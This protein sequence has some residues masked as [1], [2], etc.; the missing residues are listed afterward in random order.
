MTLLLYKKN[1]FDFSLKVGQKGFFRCVL[2][3]KLLSSR[4]IIYNFHAMTYIILSIFYSG[5]DKNNFIILYIS[6]WF[7]LLSISHDLLIIYN[8]LINFVGFLNGY[9]HQNPEKQTG[10]PLICGSLN[11]DLMGRKDKRVNTSKYTVGVATKN[12]PYPTYTLVL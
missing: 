12:N 9:F 7:S 4:H 11:W 6:S 3:P 5:Q 8:I 1:E 10:T 2:Q